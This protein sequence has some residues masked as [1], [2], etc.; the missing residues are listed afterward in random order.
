MEFPSHSKDWRKFEQNN[1]AIALNILFVT[2][3]TKRIRA[4]YVSKHNDERDN[5]VNLLM[6][7]NNDKDWHYLA[8]KSISGL[9]KGI[10]SKHKGDFYCLNCFYLCI[11]EKKLKKHERICKDHDFCH[12]KMPNEDNKILKY[13]PGEKSLKVPF[14][15]YA[16]LECLLQKI[17]VCQN[18]PEKSYT[19]KKAKHKPSGYSLVKCCSFDSTKNVSSY[20]RG[21]DCMKIFCKDLRDQAMK[22]INY[23]K[24]EMIPLTDEEKESYEN[25][26]VCYICEKE[27]CTNKNNKKE[28]KSYCK[29][30][31]HCHYTGKYRGAA[32][33]SCNLRYKIP[34]EIPVIFHNGSTY[35]YHFIIKEL[36]KEFKGNFEC[37]GENTE[38][39]ITLSVP[40]KKAHDNGKTTIYKLKFIDS[41]RFMSSSLSSL[42]DNLSGINKKEPEN[43]FIDNMRSMIASLSQ[44]IDKVSR[45]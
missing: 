17:N 28:F 18:N 19:E 42:V 37:I 36:A 25:Q 7:T 8:V 30:R 3:N 27:F 22:I 20:Y 33:S 4:A 39:Y 40:I 13:N 24:K 12:V 31:D 14:I 6:I 16:D 5:Q 38:K 26:D 11:T 35:D 44:S 15:I 1:K 2:Y 23:E 45:D 32:H 21:K 34:K 41:F 10:T 29:V 43:K 9:L